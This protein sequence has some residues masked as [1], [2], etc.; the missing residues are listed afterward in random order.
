V[1]RKLLFQLLPSPIRAVAS[2]QRNSAAFFTAIGVTPSIYDTVA[3]HGMLLSRRGDSQ[4]TMM[5]MHAS[6]TSA[7]NSF[8][9]AA[10]ALGGGGSGGCSASSLFIPCVS[11]VVPQAVVRFLDDVAHLVAEEDVQA[12]TIQVEM[13][14]MD[15]FYSAQSRLYQQAVARWATCG[16]DGAAPVGVF[17]GFSS[18]NCFMVTISDDVWVLLTAVGGSESD[19]TYSE[20]RVVVVRHTLLAEDGG[21]ASMASSLT[22]LDESVDKSEN[23]DDPASIIKQVATAFGDGPT[24]HLVSIE[25]PEGERRTVEPW[26]K[27]EQRV[28]STLQELGIEDSSSASPHKCRDSL[29]GMME[30][31]ERPNLKVVLQLLCLQSA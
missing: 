8:H 31:T 10:S 9:N 7:Q 6:P 4:D 1:S 22:I 19:C 25:G 13:P 5:S 14:S 26:A 23:E 3:S 30:R 24:A 17:S 27:T 11:Y 16:K 20:Y 15:L 12:A 21:S 2:T 18:R 28:C 29:R